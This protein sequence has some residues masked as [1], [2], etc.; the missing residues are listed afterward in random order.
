MDLSGNKVPQKSSKSNGLFS[1]S[2]LKDYFWGIPGIP[3]FQTPKSYQTGYE[4]HYIS[5]TKS[6]RNPT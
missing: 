1:F 4:S 2:H 5:P 6:H 3:H